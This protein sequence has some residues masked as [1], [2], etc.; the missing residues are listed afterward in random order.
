MSFLGG[1]LGGGSET[2]VSLPDPT[3]EERALSQLGL[4]LARQSAAQLSG[5]SS[6][7]RSLA[8][9]T[10]PSF[11]FTATP[12]TI[13]VPGVQAPAAAPSPVGIAGREAL[14]GRGDPVNQVIRD[15]QQQTLDLGRTG[16]AQDGTPTFGDTSVPTLNF[17]NSPGQVRLDE[18][19]QRLAIESLED[20]PSG[21]VPGDDAP[22]DTIADALQRLIE[23]QRESEGRIEPLLDAVQPR[24]DAVAGFTPERIDR[25][26]AAIESGAEP[27]ANERELVEQLIANL[28][29]SGESDIGRVSEE[30]L[31]LVREELG[32]QLGLSRGDT[33][34]IDRGQ[35]VAREATRSSG[36]LQNVLRAEEAR[37][38]LARPLERLGLQ[39][40]GAVPGD[41]LALNARTGALEGQLGLVGQALGL[42]DLQLRSNL[43]VV[44]G[45]GQRDQLNEAAR[46]FQA[47]L[48]EQARRFQ[49][50]LAETAAA[51]RLAFT[52]GITNTGAG[53]ATPG[54]N[55]GASA[56]SGLNENRRAGA[57]TSVTES[58][59]LGQFASGVGGVLTG[60]GAVGG[61]DLL[62]G[63]SLSSR[64]AKEDIS[65]IDDDDALAI[66]ERLPIATWRYKGDGTTHVGPMAE[67][68][69]AMTG[70]GD[71][72]TIDNRDLLGLQLA[73]TKGLAKRLDLPSGK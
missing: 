28:I 27:T 45:A 59:G 62:A 4:R 73:A 57:G 71:G 23:G 20:L 14:V 44:G 67:D 32:P 19:R 52:T 43:G 35:L 24:I 21:S 26:L 16:V 25:A 56:L 39:L 29:E 63:L 46:Q 47:E 31:R 17:G 37:L 34:L 69:H 11:G 61:G 1:G 36:Q 53:L 68:F 10:A 48:K 7:F 33:P 5:L 6:S 42:E 50:Q 38:L 40:S 49:L 9:A 65:E 22:A 41:Q 51:N 54:L 13:Q 64:K 3:P 18:L 15:R 58:L 2:T 30:S 55:F 60:L 72:V 8:A 66:V 70:L 12:G